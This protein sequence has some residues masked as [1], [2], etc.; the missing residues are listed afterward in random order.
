[1]NSIFLLE[2]KEDIDY[3][4]K[5]LLTDKKIIVISTNPNASYYLSLNKISFI[6]LSFF[7]DK[8]FN[9]EKHLKKTLTIPK[10]LESDFFSNYKCFLQYNWNVI[11]DF[12]YPI[13]INYDQLYYYT[14]C[15]NKILLRYKISKFYVNY[16]ESI[17]FSKEYIFLQKQSILYHLI[18]SKKIL[19]II[20][21]K[22]FSNNHIKKIDK[23]SFGQ[24][25]DKIKVFISDNFLIKKR[26]NYKN[27][28]IISLSS[29]EVQSLF[30]Q[31][32]NYKKDIMNL[33][34][35]NILPSE[36]TNNFV[37]KLKKNERLSNL[38]LMNNF[39]VSKLFLSQISYIS[40]FFEG[41]FNKFLFYSNTISKINTKLV[42]FTTTAPFENQNIIFNKICNLKKIPKV[43]WCHGGYCNLKLVGFDITDFKD[44]ENHFSY[45]KYLE[46]IVNEKNFLP[47]K[48]Y[49]IKYKSFDIGSPY[50][51]L[52]FKPKIQKK[53]YNKKIIFV[54][55]DMYQH[56]QSYFPS[57]GNSRYEE[58]IFNEEVLNSLKAYQH[59]YEIIFKD[60]P[61]PTDVGFW[62]EYLNE[63]GF[64]KIKYISSEQPLNKLLENNQLVI[65]PWISTTFFHSLPYKNKIFL[66][67]RWLYLKA[68]TKAKCDDE[69]GYFNNKRLF[70]KSLRL[71]LK[72]MNK[73][74]FK[75]NKKTINYFLNDN[76][77]AKIKK[78]FD[79]AVNRII[80]H[81]LNLN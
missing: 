55:G 30:I 47:K 28:N 46:Q 24:V 54:R 53:T 23:F 15:L 34:M 75:S 13:K 18:K 48:I 36:K 74:D 64:N 57:A 69:I 56:N 49:K 78:N 45:G 16:N 22:E 21:I 9:Y 52:N 5:K 76:C 14:Y 7:W 39:D 61:N 73:A 25:K 27:K 59:K 1:M 41:I 79:L 58:N 31:E 26:L 32:P 2:F 17:K 40:L 80:N 20:A 8:K 12:L 77:P 72:K 11:E 42:I 19:K 33:Y 66:Y 50:I 3:L 71:F 63:N 51:N 4:K 6:K 70:F 29:P 37:K 81:P 35:E 60:Y 10:I 68:F 38:L 67:D 62:K 44:S 65:L 43:V